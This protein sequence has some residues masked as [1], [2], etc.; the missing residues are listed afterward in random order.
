[1]KSENP[2]PLE[3]KKICV[4]CKTKLTGC[5]CKW[6]RAS[7]DNIVHLKCLSSYEKLLKSDEQKKR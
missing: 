1:M 5:S 3:P 7:D 6:R 4:Y 2:L